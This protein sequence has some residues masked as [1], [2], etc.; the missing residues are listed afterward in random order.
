MNHW[1]PKK[2][3]SPPFHTLI[4]RVGVT[5]H[6][7]DNL[8]DM[9]HEELDKK[10][11][12]VFTELKT[13]VEGISKKDFATIET[14][15][16]YVISPLAEGADQIVASAAMKCNYVLQSPLPFFK[17][18]DLNDAEQIYGENIREA[19]A[20]LELDGSHESEESKDQAY[21]AAGRMVLRHSDVL[22]AVWD[23]NNARGIGGTGQIVEEAESLR[24]PIIRI[25][26]K[27]GHEISF[28]RRKTEQ[29]LHKTDPK[30][31]GNYKDASFD[32]IKDVL[33]QKLLFHQKHHTE[34]KHSESAELKD[35]Y[36]KEKIPAR[37]FAI[38][39]KVLHK[40][41]A[42]DKKIGTPSK[43]P[44]NWTDGIKPG[45]QLFQVIE[46]IE[47]KLRPHYE[48]ADAL[49]RRYANLYNSGFVWNY[50]M[51]A[52]AVAFAFLAFVL[53]IE[54]F[55]YA[56]LFAISSIIAVYSFD[57]KRRW[58]DRRIDYRLLAE[59][60]RQTRYLATLGR[61]PPLTPPG[62]LHMDYGDPSSTWVYWHFQGIIKSI[63]LPK[64]KLTPNYLKDV[65]HLIQL[66][67]EQQSD[68]HH[69]RAIENH[70][71]EHRLH[72]LAKG[73]FI[74]AAASCGI[75]VLMEL[76]FIHHNPWMRAYLNDLPGI[77]TILAAVSIIC[78]AFGAAFAGIR[79]QG[80]FQR[81]GRHN[82][83]MKDYLKEKSEEL[84]KIQ[85]TPNLD[86]ATLARIVDDIAEKLIDEVLDWRIVFHKRPIE[87]A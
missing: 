58:Y 61:I 9:N 20:I 14:D 50:L 25:D 28:Y 11:V 43:E 40:L 30:N 66:E 68:Y 72:K 73:L 22:I 35:Q 5:G 32:E 26:P 63:G 41:L 53:H 74:I 15:L 75:H 79:S 2:G 8:K 31:Q 36:F 13:Y 4:L 82:A 45:S 77:N 65:A 38:V 49:A 55:G 54:A 19:E 29:E 85:R 84:K 67:A 51:S 78:P 18:E 33:A 1:N 17:P 6:R 81:V 80:E 87:L 86:S 57:S 34:S 21:E 71:L 47:S 48:Y 60:V 64:A 46:N 69:R 16:F 10:L 70:N 52:S 56:E 3:D 42:R 59:L 24:I 12:Q 23:R 62:P 83:A 44:T 27:S 37:N 76:P 39:W 7:P